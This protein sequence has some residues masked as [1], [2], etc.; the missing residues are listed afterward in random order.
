MPSKERHLKVYINQHVEPTMRQF[1]IITCKFIDPK[2]DIFFGT[3]NAEVEVS[4]NLEYLMTEVKEE[5]REWFIAHV[6]RHIADPYA[7]ENDLE[8]T[9][10]DNNYIELCQTCQN[11]W[12]D[13]QKSLD[14]E[15]F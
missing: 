9:E 12:E 2:G 14:R 4:F 7:S 10:E 11:L 3:S 8:V 1:A 5:H 13:Y 6:V 15:D